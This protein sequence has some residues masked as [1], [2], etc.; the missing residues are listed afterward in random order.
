MFFYQLTA[1]PENGF[2]GYNAIP[3]SKMDYSSLSLVELKKIARDHTPKIKSYYT[4]RRK[5]LIDILSLE[6][7]PERMKIEKMKVEELR[8]EAKNRGLKGFWK[9]DKETLIEL[10]YPSSQKNN[11]NNNHTKEHDDPQASECE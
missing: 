7:F 10:L 8:A 6:V 4:M 3:G 9:V 11:K 5:E 2:R 1:I